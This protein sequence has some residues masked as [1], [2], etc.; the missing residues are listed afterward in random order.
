MMFYTRSFKTSDGK[1]LSASCI[2]GTNKVFVPNVLQQTKEKLVVNM[3]TLTMGIKTPGRIYI[4]EDLL[5]VC[6]K[7]AGLDTNNQRN[8]N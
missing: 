6:T 8:T 7:C 1:I 2:N 3:I 5:T 4:S